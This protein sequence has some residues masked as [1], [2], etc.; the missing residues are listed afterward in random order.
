MGEYPMKVLT[1]FFMM[2]VADFFKDQLSWKIAGIL[3]SIIVVGMLLLRVFFKF[4]AWRAHH[5]GNDDA[6]A[7]HEVQ[8]A[9][10][11]AV[12]FMVVPHRCTAPVWFLSC[13]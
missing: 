13:V 3:V 11:I 9:T 10:S 8:A 1:L 12:L 2:T 4:L 6:A 5:W 7:R